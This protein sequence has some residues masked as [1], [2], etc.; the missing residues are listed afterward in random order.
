[1]EGR[2]VPDGSLPTPPPIEPAAFRAVLRQVPAA[3]TVIAAGPVGQRAGLTA[4]AVCP[5]SDSPPTMLVCVNRSASAHDAIIAAGHFSVNVLAVGQEEI[6]VRFSGRL[7]LRGEARFLDAHWFTLE[8][9]AP[10]LAGALAALDCD[11]IEAK[12]VATHSVLIGRVVSSRATTGVQ[13]LLYHDGN[14]IG[15]A[16]TP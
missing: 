9:G 5:L 10:V 4:T 2:I 13:P 1:M 8:S 6:A 14:Y 3:V 16:H 12:A 11:L 7:G 15:V